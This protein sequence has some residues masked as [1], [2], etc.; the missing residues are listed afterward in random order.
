[1]KKLTLILLSLFLFFLE[2]SFPVDK[3]CI[4]TEFLLDDG[5]EI[6]I[7]SYDN[8]F[9]A[10][11]DNSFVATQKQLGK[12]VPI[13][14]NI[15]QLKVFFDA[16][17]NSG[18]KVIRIAHYGDSLIQGDVISEYLRDRFQKK[19]S[20]KGAGY[21][22]II[23]N[24]IKIRN[25]TK[26]TYSDDWNYVA[27]T[28]RNPERL[29][30][31][32]GGS[33]AV[34]KYGSWVKYQATQYL[35]STNSFDLIKIY[36]SHA[37]ESSTI[38]YVINEKTSKKIKLKSGVNVQELIL[39]LDK[40]STSV[41][42]KFISGKIPYLYSVS[43]ESG[44]GIYLDNFAMPGNTGSSLLDIPKNVISDFNKYNEYRLVVLNY[45]ANVSSPNKGIYTLYENKMVTLI[46]EFKKLFPKAGFLLVGVGDKTMKKGN[47]FITN[48]DVPLLLESQ[49]RIVAKTNIA[50]WNLWEAMGGNNSM[51]EWV[52]AKPPMALKDFAHFTPIGGARVA[53]LF[54]DAIIDAYNKF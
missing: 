24:D 14:G 11:I 33:V 21:L 52:N 17:K 35:S 18:G 12:F 25:T 10:D 22:A 19:F 43:L 34:P 30:F 29:P 6:F 9:P 47:N 1:M 32:I 39:E 15:N 48:P 16:L 53:E 20:G 26:H 8:S 27:I 23:S 38:E 40:N 54:F 42:I 51:N 45:G 13:T 2:Q 5:Q 44:N 7:S 37:D 41:E 4:V 50:F 49:K 3:N 28:T 36:Y 46:E 31:G